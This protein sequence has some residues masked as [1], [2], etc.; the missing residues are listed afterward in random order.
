[1]LR[2]DELKQELN[3]KREAAKAIQD[4]VATAKRIKNEDERTKFDGIMNE[5]ERIQAEVKDAEAIERM[6]FSAPAIHTATQKAT[7]R[8]YNPTKALNEFRSSRILT[9]VEAEVTQELRRTI[10]GEGLIIP[11]ELIYKRAETVANSGSLISEIATG[12]DIIETPSL[13][14]RLGITQYPGLKNEVKLTFADQLA[15]TKAAEGS[16]LS[17]VT[18]TK[19]E[20]KLSGERI[21]HI[22][23][24]TEEVM[25]VTSIFI[26]NLR[27]ADSAIKTALVKEIFAGILATTGCTL[28]GYESSASG[29]TI[30]AAILGALRASILAPAFNNP[31]FAMQSAIYSYCENAQAGTSLK[32]IIN[33]GRING[34]DAVDVMNLLTVGSS[35]YDILFG[36][37]ARAY[38]GWFND[39]ILVTIDPY[40]D[41]LAT[42][43]V[44]VRFSR[45]GDSAFN[46]YAFKTIQNAAIA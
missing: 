41:N 28:T 23:P 4:T 5:I 13:I 20:G 16:S 19:L 9:G 46:P 43:A 27:T 21:G 7:N 38:I 40:G 2:S 32:T 8:K 31:K 45:M 14:E 26:D 22:V 35:K 30:T 10:S 6:Q 11:R 39:A 34:Y 37:W 3:L 18:H 42:G 44:N 24:M 17:A 29:V 15:S 36:D 33:E 25:N 1:M 12:L